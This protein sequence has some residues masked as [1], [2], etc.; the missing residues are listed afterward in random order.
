M[1]SVGFPRFCPDESQSPAAEGGNTFAG[2]TAR[3]SK[4]VLN[5]VPASE[6][7]ERSVRHLGCPQWRKR[8]SARKL[9]L[10]PPLRGVSDPP[11]GS[12]PEQPKGLG[13]R[14]G[15]RGTVGE[16]SVGS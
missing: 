1:V 16:K 8:V 15:Q 2:C 14:V 10:I 11:R 4:E 12:C 6:P 13:I 7:G 3:V 5:L 9:F